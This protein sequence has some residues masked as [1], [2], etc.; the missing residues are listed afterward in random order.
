M[1]K[2]EHNTNIKRFGNSLGKVG[3]MVKIGRAL[4]V[5]AFPVAKSPARDLVAPPVL[6][7]AKQQWN[8]YGR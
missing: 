8:A 5:F 2:E 6:L 1:G 4:D 3:L 7:Q